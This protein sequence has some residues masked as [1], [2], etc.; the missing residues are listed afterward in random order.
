MTWSLYVAWLSWNLLCGPDWPQLR[1]S[2]ASVSPTSGLMVCT[3][4]PSRKCSS[5][6]F[7]TSQM[8][9]TRCPIKFG[10]SWDA[11]VLHSMF[12]C[13]SLLPSILH[14]TSLSQ[15]AGPGLPAHNLPC[16]YLEMR[17]ACRFCYRLITLSIYDTILQTFLKTNGWLSLHLWH[18]SHLEITLKYHIQ[19][20]KEKVN[21]ILMNSEFIQLLNHRIRVLDWTF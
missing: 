21:V 14:V 20:C 3:T 15:H 1:D 7:P 4:M 18:K 2:A 12:L 9:F 16:L 13:S 19:V 17:A 6:T 5:L 8:F 11:P 10:V